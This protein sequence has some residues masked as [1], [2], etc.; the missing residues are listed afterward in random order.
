MD[1]K[2]PLFVKVFKK[3]CVGQLRKLFF[4]VSIHTLSYI[5]QPL[6]MHT[7]V[8]L[9]IFVD[10]VLLVEVLEKSLGIVLITCDRFDKGLQ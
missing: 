7:I 6:S 8:F 5:V 4:S 1:G 9:Y 10:F 2:K 3:M